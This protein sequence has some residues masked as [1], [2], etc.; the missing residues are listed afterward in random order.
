MSFVRRVQQHLE[1]IYA[2]EQPQQAAEYLVDEE[3]ARAL[4]GTCRAHE[5]LLV[6]DEG[7][8]LEVGLYLSAE[9]L[10]RMKRYEDVPASVLLEEGLSP[11]CQVAEG[12]SHFLY[13]SHTASQER[14]VSL[15][16]LEAQAEV[17]K[18]ATCAL[19]RWRDGLSWA[20]ALFQQL[21]HRVDYHP[22]LVPEERRRYERANHLARNY[23]QKL[24]PHF[25]ERRLEPL[26]GD[27]R[28]SYRLGAQAKIR[29]LGG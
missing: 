27:L 17:D 13:L 26:L 5:E 14:Q 7:D 24:L 12:V 19:L 3:T 21:F 15:L 23:C 28:Y 22:H 20:K 11:Y 2:I 4:G 8:D 1:T 9:L 10:D 18:F 6:C 29:H 25:A 16:E